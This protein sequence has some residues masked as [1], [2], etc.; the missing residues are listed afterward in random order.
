M[1]KSIKHIHETSAAVESLLLIE[2]HTC[3]M[4]CCYEINTESKHAFN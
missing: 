4:K 1:Q 2:A 3:L